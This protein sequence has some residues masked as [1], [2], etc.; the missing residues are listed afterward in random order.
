MASKNKFG[1]CL[2]FIAGLCLKLFGKSSKNGPENIKKLH[3][4]TST[5]RIGLGFT[6]KIRAAFRGR[7]L[8]K[9]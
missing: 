5:Q 8:K 1:S 6:E 2:G 3:F 9:H 7:W 4:R